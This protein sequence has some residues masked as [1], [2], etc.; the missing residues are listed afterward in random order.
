MKTLT[1]TQPWASLIALGEKQVETRSWHTNYRGPLAIHAAISFPGWAKRQC[2]MPPFAGVLAGHDL[3]PDTLPLG[4]VLCITSIV[5][6]LRTE[7]ISEAWC[8]Y[9]ESIHEE[10]FGNFAPGR[11]GFVLQHGIE[12]VFDPPPYAKGSLGLWEWSEPR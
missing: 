5:D 10:A 3:S 2:F 4:R 6:C 7:Q 1:L 12:K 8:L 9:S 11:F